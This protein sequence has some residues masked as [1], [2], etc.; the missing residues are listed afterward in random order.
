MKRH[1]L[2][3]LSFL[4]VV[5]SFTSCEDLEVENRNRP[6]FEETNLPSQ[7]NGTVGGLFNSWYMNAVDYDGIALAF[8]MTADAGSCSW[9]N[10]GMQ[11]LSSEPRS[12]FVNDPAYPNMS[13]FEAYY[14]GMYSTLNTANDALKAIANRGD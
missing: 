3:V 9:G 1:I 10:V 11:D 6:K 14:N 4:L 5:F 13:A 2:I 8:F 7:V 12:E